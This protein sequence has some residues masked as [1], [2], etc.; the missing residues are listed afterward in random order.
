MEI[1]ASA[2]LRHIYCLSA[3]RDCRNGIS[4]PL[5]RGAYVRLNLNSCRCEINPTINPNSPI[6]L[7]S[8][9]RRCGCDITVTSSHCGWRNDAWIATQSDIDLAGLQGVMGCR[10]HIGENSSSGSGY[11]WLDRSR[12]MISTSLNKMRICLHVR[13]RL[14]GRARSLHE[15][16][17]R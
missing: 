14:R 2:D 8:Y 13:S 4:T 16:D 11:G 7:R 12:E 9:G 15:L 5:G 6:S 3:A 10:G 1:E 17:D